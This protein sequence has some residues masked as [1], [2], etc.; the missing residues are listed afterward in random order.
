M[1]KSRG[2]RCSCR[3]GPGQRA[4]P[5]AAPPL[6]PPFPARRRW[7]PRWA[8]GRD[9]LRQLRAVRGAGL[10]RQPLPARHLPG[11][12]RQRHGPSPESGL[13]R[14]RPGRRCPRGRNGAE[15]ERLGRPQGGWG[16]EELAGLPALGTH[17]RLSAV[18]DAGIWSEPPRS[19]PAK[20]VS[21]GLAEPV[22]FGVA[23]WC[24]A[25]GELSFSSVS[26]RRG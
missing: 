24:R 11:G 26:Q 5:A 12:R 13:G 20:A 19:P 17:P 21:A 25:G 22:A 1:Y 15:G 6:L 10:R 7:E 14:A 23:W 16:R 3:P 4:G 18:R 2:A 8:P 9:A